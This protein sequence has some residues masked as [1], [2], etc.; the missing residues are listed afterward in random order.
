MVL[1]PGRIVVYLSLGQAGF[2]V[3]GEVGGFFSV[4]G[5]MGLQVL[6]RD[7]LEQKDNTTKRLNYNDYFGSIV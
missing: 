3:R 2:N 7:D 6:V 4:V 5:N 1:K